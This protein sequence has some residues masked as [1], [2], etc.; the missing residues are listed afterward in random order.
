MR[1]IVERDRPDLLKL[2]TALVGA[3]PFERVADGTRFQQPAIFCASLVGWGR[4]EDQSPAALAGHSLGEITALV[5]SGALEETDGLRLVAIRGRLMQEAGEAADG[6][7]IAVRAGRS[8]IEP[9]IAGT[10]AVIANDN[11]PQQVVL[12]GPEPALAQAQAQ[13]KQAGIRA[14]RLPVSAAFHSPV[15]EPA[16]ASFGEAIR[17]TSF[18]PSQVPVVSC[19][20]AAVAADPGAALVQGLTSQVR[21]VETQRELYARGIRRFVETGPGSVLKGLVR[22]TLPD[23]EVETVELD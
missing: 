4:A 11:A 3:D 16:V 22:R 20:L 17:E 2:A 23:V 8:D 15:M 18:A 14:L 19:S 5:A 1:G 9:L 21:W 7:M 13:M 12:S 6:G 10:G